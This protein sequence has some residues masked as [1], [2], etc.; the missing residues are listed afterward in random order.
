M[1]SLYKKLVQAFIQPTL[2]SYGSCE[3]IFVSSVSHSEV[4]PSCV[5]DQHVSSTGLGPSNS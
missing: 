1:Q 4:A 2:P 3:W 5:Y